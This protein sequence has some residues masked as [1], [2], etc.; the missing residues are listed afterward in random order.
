MSTQQY[1]WRDKSRLQRLY[2]EE[3][4]SSHEVAE[5]LDCSASTVR[6]WLK[7]HDIPIR[8][9]AEAKE[10]KTSNPFHPSFRTAKR[11]DVVC[12]S[13]IKTDDGFT[14]KTLYIH[15]LI[16]VAEHGFD[17]VCGMDVHHKN[18]IKWDNRPENLELLSHGEHTDIHNRKLSWLQ[19]LAI[20]E[21]YESTD[22]TWEDLGKV[23][24]VDP[25]TIGNVIHGEHL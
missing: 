2:I 22:S 6:D 8:S 13:S 15:R 19:K 23:Y 25:T 4:K 20:M 5:E 24:S 12:E 16:M 18:H 7:R 9:I 3:K 1:P 11:G 21:Q 10:Y 17:A 14:K